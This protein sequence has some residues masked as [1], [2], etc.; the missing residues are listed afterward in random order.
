MVR[1][2]KP[3]ALKVLQGTQRPGRVNRSEP[4]P[5]AMPLSRRPPTWLS[6][7]GKTAWREIVPVLRRMG[8]VTVADPLALSMLADAVGEYREARTVVIEEGATYWT[9]GQSRMLRPRP[10]VAIASDAWR[11]SKQLLTEF[12]LTPASR[13]R[14]SGSPEKDEDPLDTWMKSKS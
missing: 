10:E 2:T 5:L 6:P 14:V 7:R 3:T 9:E 11:R 8:V 4:K 12:G 13:G 1:P